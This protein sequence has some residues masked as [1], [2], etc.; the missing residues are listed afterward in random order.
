MLDC[1]NV[2]LLTEPNAPLFDSPQVLSPE[3]A[4]DAHC[5]PPFFI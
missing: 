1:S 5:V 2:P 3:S 4:V